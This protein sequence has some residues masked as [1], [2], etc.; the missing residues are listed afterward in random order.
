MLRDITL[1][2]FSNVTLPAGLTRHTIKNSEIPATDLRDL[3]A[4]G[5]L[6][7]VDASDVTG[8]WNLSVSE[9]GEINVW[10]PYVGRNP[11][12][13]LASLV[14]GQS[15]IP[16]SEV[17]NGKVIGDEGKFYLGW[18]CG[19]EGLMMVPLRLDKAQTTPSLKT[20]TS[21]LAKS[22]LGT[23]L[24]ETKVPYPPLSSLPV[25]TY[26]ATGWGSFSSSFGPSF[27][28][29]I[30][31]VRYK[32]NKKVSDSLCLDPTITPE[33]PATLTITGHKTT[34]QGH[35]MV[36][37]LFT[38]DFGCEEDDM[39]SFQFNQMAEE[40]EGLGLDHIS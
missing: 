11:S 31:G 37:V 21:A 39:P 8:W 19:S 25:G 23:F 38:C 29:E 34:K 1:T 40:L 4:W 27:Y 35:P 28:L 7:G 18:D 5:E 30:N 3:Q 15:Q 20:L 36:A 2:R 17:Q 33:Q 16:L 6:S 32:A 26:Q 9:E 14:L 24:A 13:G 12:T 10:G 22:T